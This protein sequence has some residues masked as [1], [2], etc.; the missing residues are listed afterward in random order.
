MVIFRDGKELT[1]AQ[2]FESLKMTAYDLS[3]DMMDVHADNSTLHRFDRLSPSFYYAAQPQPQPSDEC[4][5]IFMYAQSQS[6]ALAA[7]CDSNVIYGYRFNLKYN[8]CGSSRLREIFLKTDNKI[9]GEYLAGIT[10]V[11]VERFG[12][13]V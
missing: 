2:V 10:Q 9:K 8:P 13:I 12:A 6:T 1:L 4:A 5:S 11:G 7:S 3:L